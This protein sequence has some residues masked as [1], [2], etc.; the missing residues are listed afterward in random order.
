M[1]QL[2]PGFE[3]KQYDV[4][5]QDGQITIGIEVQVCWWAWPRLIFDYLRERYQV[6]WW[7]WPHALWIILLCW[8]AALRER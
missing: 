4:E 1:A 8:R 7:Q 5:Q 6:R 2:P 3:V